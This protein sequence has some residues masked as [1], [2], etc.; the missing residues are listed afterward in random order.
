MDWKSPHFRHLL[1]TLF[2]GAYVLDRDRKIVHWN[3]AA[4]EL[5]GIGEEDMV[6]RAC[7]DDRLEHVDESGC[8][9]CQD[10]CP[11]AQTLMDGESREEEVFLRHADGHRLPVKVRSLPLTDG[12]GRIEAVLETFTAVRS[13]CD[14]TSRLK[15]LE[16]LARDDSLTGIGNRRFLE[17][18]VACRLDQLRRFGW[19]FGILFADLDDFKLIND[20][21]GHTHGDRF[22]VAAARTLAANLR[23]D[24]V[25]CRYGGEEFIAVVAAVDGETLLAIAE[26]FRR[27]LRGTWLNVDGTRARVTASIGVTLA[28]PDDSR[29]SLLER[30]DALMYEG[31]RKGKDQVVAG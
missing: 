7:H 16:R 10:R 8:G 28:H 1:D 11:V 2:E 9:L 29:E 21:F 24:D 15:E 13:A 27:L 19:G 12:S 22:L 20:Q 3:R 17:E 6:G 23:A 31:K 5:T 26:R 25:A 18:N 14:L 4:A 30:A